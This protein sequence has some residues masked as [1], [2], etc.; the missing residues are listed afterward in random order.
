MFLPP[1][2]ACALLEE[3]AEHIEEEE[4]TSTVEV[5]EETFVVIQRN[6]VGYHVG[7]D[8][9]DAYDNQK[10]RVYE[11]HDYKERGPVTKESRL[12]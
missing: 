5:R 1:R 4:N 2:A 8:V 12:V 3:E 11:T 6:V 7:Y 9:C 10:L